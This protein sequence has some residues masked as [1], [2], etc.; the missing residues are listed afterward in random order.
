MRVR[1]YDIEWDTDDGE[2][3]A[4]TAES[5]GLPREVEMEVAGDVDLEESG[6]DLL[7]DKYGFCVK[8]FSFE[9]RS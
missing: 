6:A 9:V 4:P 7:S 3:N 5:L 8:G 1:F 2:G